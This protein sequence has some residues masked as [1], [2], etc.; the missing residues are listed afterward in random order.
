M[1]YPKFIKKGETIGICA[2]SAGVGKD[3]DEYL[4]S[5]KVLKK[6]G[7]KIVET[8]SVRSKKSCS[9]SAKTRAKEFYELTANKDVDM[10]MFATG[11]D[12]MFEMMPYVNYDKF[13]EN[14][15]WLMG[16]SDPTNILL[17]V[18]CFLDVATLYGINARSYKLDTPLWQ[19]NNLEYLKGN[20][21][22]QKSFKKCQE[23]CI[24]AWNGD[25]SLKH[26]VKWISKKPVDIEGRIIGGCFDVMLNHMGTFLDNMASFVAR[27]S[28]DGIIWY[29]DIYAKTTLDVYLGLLQMKYAGLFTNCKG[30]LIGRVAAPDKSNPELDYIKA[31]DKALGNIPHIMEMDIGHTNPRITI[32]NGAIAHVKCKD[33]KG[34]IS[35]KLK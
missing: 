8:K 21:I 2:P 15:K 11:G 22:K 14:P 10:I 26:D 29:F 13:I 19:K 5:I 4:E 25:Y 7:Y 18:T 9:A 24:D 31:A 3:L 6:Q 23:S 17:D 16:M 20:L 1:K 32:I 33:G 34:E 27:Y 30:V 35:F 12:Y 28:D